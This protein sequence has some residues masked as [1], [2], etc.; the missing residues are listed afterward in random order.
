MQ[1]HLRLRL[2]TQ[3]DTGFLIGCVG[4]EGGEEAFRLVSC[5]RPHARRDAG[6]ERDAVRVGA[7]E[8]VCRHRLAARQLA[9]H[10]SASGRRRVLCG[11]HPKS[12]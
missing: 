11:R 6:S 2:M 5:R 7:R 12:A 4:K 1:N 3:P 9:A 10:A 8:I